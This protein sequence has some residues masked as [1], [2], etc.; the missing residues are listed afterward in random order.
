MF[1]LGAILE[2]IDQRRGVPQLGSPFGSLE[3]RLLGPSWGALGALLGAPG[4][5][6][7]LSWAPLGALL[8]PLGAN[9]SFGW[10]S[11]AKGRECKNQCFSLV[12]ERFWL[13]GGLLGKLF[14]LLEPSWGG[15]GASWSIFGAILR[16]LRL[17]CAILELILGSPRRSWSLFGRKSAV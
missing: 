1:P 10:P 5:V 11:E 8:G 15:L 2:E 4:A 17:S 13:L 14:G 3:N 12:F 16:H 6:M 9:L 7:G